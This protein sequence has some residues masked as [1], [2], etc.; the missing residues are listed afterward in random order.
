MFSCENNHFSES[1]WP[2][3]VIHNSQWTWLRKITFF[4]MHQQNQ[5]LFSYI[6]SVIHVLWWTC[7][8]ILQIK[9]FGPLKICV[10]FFFLFLWHHIW[11]NENLRWMNFELKEI[12]YLIFEKTPNLK[13]TLIFSLLSKTSFSVMDTKLKSGFPNMMKYITK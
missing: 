11:R 6:K 4:L 2:I 8:L 10:N 3:V 7:N 12:P 13:K 9:K 1:N 5:V